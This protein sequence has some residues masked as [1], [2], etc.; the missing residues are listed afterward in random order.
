MFTTTCFIVMNEGQIK[1]RI[2]LIRTADVLFLFAVLFLGIYFVVYSEHNIF[3]GTACIV[4]LFLV[5][6]S[7]HYTAIAIVNLGQELKKLQ[8][9][10]NK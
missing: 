5:N 1:T 6:K 7:G 10:Q 4:G 3:M 8:R 9:E 2:F